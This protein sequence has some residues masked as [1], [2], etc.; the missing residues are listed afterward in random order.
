MS[1]WRASF[2]PSSGKRAAPITTFTHGSATSH[3]SSS[4][5]GSSPLSTPGLS[6]YP[7]DVLRRRGLRILL[8][9]S[10]TEL[11]PDHVVLRHGGVLRTMT[12]IWCAGIAPSPLVAR[13][14]VPTDERGWLVCERDMKVS[15]FDNV[16]AL[17]DSASV[18]DRD[19]NPYPATAQHAVQQAAQLAV[20]LAQTVRGEPTRPCDISSRGALA[21]L[22]CRTAVADLPGFRLFGFA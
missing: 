14:G 13:L 3:S 11:T 5:P 20:N 22:G 21:A 1:R 10:V 12:V 4:P 7:R 19:G 8:G 6:A 15:G 17:G 18:P 2:T 16:W 9:T